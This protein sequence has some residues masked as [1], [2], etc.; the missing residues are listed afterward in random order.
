MYPDLHREDG[1]DQTAQDPDADYATTWAE[2]YEWLHEQDGGPNGELTGGAVP[3]DGRQAP[4]TRPAGA[5]P[6]GAI[7]TV[8]SHSGPYFLLDWRGNGGGVLIR[9]P[10]LPPRPTPS[11]SR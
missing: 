5:K 8:G 1:S 10:G 11:L 6:A 9:G 3:V 7:D 2:E 4:R